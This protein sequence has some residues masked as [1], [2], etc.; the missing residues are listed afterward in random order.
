MQSKPVK[1]LTLWLVGIIFLTVTGCGKLEGESRDPLNVKLEIPAGEM[2]EVFWFNVDRKVLV[3]K[4]GTEESAHPWAGSQET[5]L[6]L[7]AG[8][9]LLFSGFDGRGLLLVTGEARV[10]PA[11]LVSIPVRRVL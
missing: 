2:A 4:R 11:K 10:G 6:D 5:E 1:F 7:R 3:I 9:T 8:D